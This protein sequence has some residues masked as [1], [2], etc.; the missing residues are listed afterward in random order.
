MK[1][2]FIPIFTFI[3]LFS[4]T[5]AQRVA[6]GAGSPTPHPSSVLDL[7][8]TDKGFLIPRIANPSSINSPATGLMVYNTTTNK[9][10]YYNG[11]AWTEV[12]ATG[13]T[14]P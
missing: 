7:Q 12:G 2:L 13:P 1:K 14:G 3:A 10:N 11:T 9:F 6:I 5:Q 8:A 4:Q